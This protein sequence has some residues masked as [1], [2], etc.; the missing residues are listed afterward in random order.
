[1]KF[2]LTHLY[3]L[4]LRPEGTQQLKQDQTQRVNVHFVRVGVPREL[5]TNVRTCKK[6]QNQTV[7]SEKSTAHLLGA[8]VE[9]GA[10]LTRVPGQQRGRR[11]GAR[12]VVVLLL[13]HGRHQTEVSN[14]HHIIHGE[15]DVGG[16][17]DRLH[18]T[19]LRRNLPFGSDSHEA[20]TPDSVHVHIDFCRAI[21]KCCLRGLLPLIDAAHAAL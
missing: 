8:H 10:D 17:S 14:L 7:P 4:H 19:P 15:E 6:T 16:L 5:Q 9:F 20:A 13:V 12:P 11:Q 21:T 3:S 18:N 1:M 2:K